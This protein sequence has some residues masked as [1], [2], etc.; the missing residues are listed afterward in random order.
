MTSLLGPGICRPGNRALRFLLRSLQYPPGEYVSRASRVLAGGRS[1]PPLRTLETDAGPLGAF[2]IT[3]VAKQNPRQRMRDW[4]W[5]LHRGERIEFEQTPP[6]RLLV[7]FVDSH[8][9][10]IGTVQELAV[11]TERPKQESGMRITDLIAALERIKA[12][13]GNLPSL[14]RRPCLD[15][16]SPC[17]GEADPPVPGPSCRP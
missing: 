13:Q 4:F 16:G 7:D 1:R 6:S 12:E 11:S 14:R 15:G 3:F 2:Q 17:R 9:A 8:E 5:T 10:N